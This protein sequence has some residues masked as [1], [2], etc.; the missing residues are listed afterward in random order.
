MVSEFFNEDEP[1]MDHKIGQKVSVDW[2]ENWEVILEHENENTT[3]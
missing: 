3:F 1:D 2:I